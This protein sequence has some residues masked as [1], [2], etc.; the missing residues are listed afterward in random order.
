M[1][2]EQ[3]VKFLAQS[4]LYPLDGEGSHWCLRCPRLHNQHISLC[5]NELQKQH[6]KMQHR[7]VLYIASSPSLIW[8]TASESTESLLTWQKFVL[9]LRTVVKSVLWAYKQWSASD[10][11]GYLA[12]SPY[13]VSFSLV[14]LDCRSKS[15]GECE[16]YFCCGISGLQLQ[17]DASVHANVNIYTVYTIKRWVRIIVFV[18]VVTIALQTIRFG[19]SYAIMYLTIYQAGDGIWSL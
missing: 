7:T 3:E 11:P 5:H 18:T 15:P 19:F 2:F 10:V 9:R 14:S 16:T 4:G 8:T 1:S 12:A 6:L 17:P 13:I